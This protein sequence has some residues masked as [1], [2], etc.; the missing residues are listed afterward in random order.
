MDIVVNEFLKYIGYEV[1]NKLWK[2]I[3][4]IS[5]KG[6]VASNYKNAL[7]YKKER[8]IRNPCVRKVTRVSVVIMGGLACFM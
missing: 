3:N 5:K 8:C 1:R 4:T 2:I 6:E 7:M